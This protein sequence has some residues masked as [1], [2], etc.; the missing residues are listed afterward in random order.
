[1]VRVTGSIGL[2]ASVAEAAGMLDAEPGALVLAGGTDLMVAVNTGQLAPARVVSLRR[3]DELRR[4]H[5]DGDELVLGARVTFADLERPEL[6]ALAPV[7]AQAARTVGSPQVRNAGTVGGNIATASPGGD[8]LPVLCAL[9]AAVLI[10]GTG[11]SREVAVAELVAAGGHAAL[12]PGELIEAVRV[13]LLD[14]PQEYC[15]VGTRNAM[16]DSVAGVAVVVDLARHS[17][18]CA[19]GAVGP[20]P[21]RAYAAELW[22]IPEIDWETYRVH[23]PSVYERFGELVAEAAQPVGDD[24]VDTAYRKHAVTVCARRALIRVLA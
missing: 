17:V 22:L 24:P 2:P 20:A 23:H 3:V 6:A 11:G 4:W 13:P 19:L 12:R 8:L 5:Q 9:G 10:R 21:V 16:T 7:L 18:R 15:K 14:G 1:M